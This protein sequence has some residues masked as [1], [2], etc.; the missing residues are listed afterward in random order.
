MNYH[1]AS[2]NATLSQLSDYETDFEKADYLRLI[3]TNQS[4]DDGPAN[5]EHYIFL[6]Q[7]FL[8]RPDTKPLI[9]SWIR[10]NR[11]LSQ[12][13]QFIKQKFSH[14]A[15]RRQFIK[16]EM[17]PLLDHLENNT[18]SPHINSVDKELKILNSDYIGQT[19]EK[20]L[21]RKSNDPD[22]AITIAKTLL[23]SVLKHI[24]DEVKIAYPNDADLHSLYK[25][26]AKSINL[27]SDQHTE[28]IFKQILGGCAGA[29]SGLSSLRNKLGDAHGQGKINYQPS[30]RH[31]ELA[32]NLAGTLCLFLLKTYEFNN[33]K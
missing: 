17:N 13:W 14:Y 5:N 24:L 16:E 29:V 6:R 30:E 12:F 31:A 21:Q 33:K 32:V 19:W 27:S 23:E 18:I 4:T 10:I 3:L 28:A 2:S 22:G 15:E 1:E 26:V 20:A 25:S 9:P 11:D 7:Y 8:N